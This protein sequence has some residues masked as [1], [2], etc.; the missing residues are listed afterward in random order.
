M[1]DYW[2]S[3]EE[4]PVREWQREVST[5]DTRL[6]YWAWVAEMKEMASA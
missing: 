3:D 4:F 2:S 6:G 1:T 5:D